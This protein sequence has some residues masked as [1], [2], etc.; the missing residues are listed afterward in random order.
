MWRPPPPERRQL[1]REALAGVLDHWVRD[2][3]AY[4]TPEGGWPLG[5]STSSGETW[6]HILYV[7]TDAATMVGRY[8]QTVWAVE[9]AEVS[10]L[11]ELARRA[12][13]SLARLAALV[14]IELGEP[15]DREAVLA[16]AAEFL[17]EVDEEDDGLGHA[18]GA[19]GSLLQAKLVCLEEQVALPAGERDQAAVAILGPL[20]AQAACLRWP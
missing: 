11:Q 2:G 16:Q 6:S 7:A 13:A 20:V 19:L 10:Q 5:R 15:V 9:D 4:L 1:A 8:S 17:Q 12:S 3:E 18:S 14:L